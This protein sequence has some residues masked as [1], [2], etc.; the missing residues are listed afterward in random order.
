MKF[1]DLQHNFLLVIDEIPHSLEVMGIANL[2][3]KEYE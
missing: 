2:Y 1:W 3:E